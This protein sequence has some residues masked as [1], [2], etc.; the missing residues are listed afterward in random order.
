MNGFGKLL[1][2]RFAKAAAVAAAALTLVVGT[3]GQANA[4]IRWPHIQVVDQALQQ[5]IAADYDHPAGAAGELV[6]GCMAGGTDWIDL[7]SAAPDNSGHA[8]VQIQNDYF[9]GLADCLTTGSPGYG[10]KG[11]TVTGWATCN[12]NDP[13]QLWTMITA[14]P[15][16]NVGNPAGL[17]HF[18]NFY[19]ASPG[20]NVCLDGGIGLYGFPGQCST[21]NNWQIWN[22]YTNLGSY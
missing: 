11:G 16:Q 20:Y 5:C 15:P 9:T 13:G 12:V 21:T 6:P 4:A 7:I 10:P 2:G 18:I 8:V 17:K 3:T 22:V 19:N 1:S 14:A